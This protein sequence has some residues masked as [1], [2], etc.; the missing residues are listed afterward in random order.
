MN[1][2]DNADNLLFVDG[3]EAGAEDEEET[4]N[5]DQADIVEEK[6][7]D[8]ATKETTEKSEAQP[9]TQQPDKT[10]ARVL[11]PAQIHYV[12]FITSDFAMQNV[13]IQMGF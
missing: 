5:K 6:K 7:A 12:K 2:M 1:L 9:T 8:D 4:E 13:I 10:V 11:D 3:K